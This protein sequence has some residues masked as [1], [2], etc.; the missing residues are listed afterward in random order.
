MTTNKTPINIVWFKRDLR[1]HDNEALHNA[2]NAPHKTLLVYCFEP[3]LLNDPHYSERHWNFIKQSLIDLNK[4][5]SLYQTKI[6]CVTS[7]IIPLLQALNET[8]D[9]KHIF[10]HQKPESTSPSKGTKK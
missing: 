3:L 5:L 9:I 1:L 6:L 7:D 10:S 4:T 2:L 8:F